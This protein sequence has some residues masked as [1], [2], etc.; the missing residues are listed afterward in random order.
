MKQLSKRILSLVLITSMVL[1][2]AACS[3]DSKTTASKEEPKTITLWHTWPTGTNKVIIDKFIEEYQQKNNVIIKAEATQVDEYQQR[4]LKVAISG[5]SVA[6]V[7]LTYGAGYSKPF[8]DAKAVL[9]LEPYLKKDE[10]KDRIVEGMAEYFTYNSKTYGLPIKSWAGVLFCNTELFKA[11]G[12]EIPK[13]MD[14]LMLAVKA[15]R[16]KDITPMV[17][18]AKDAWHIGMIQNALAVRTAGAEYV[19]KALKGEATFDTPEIVESAKLLVDL[20]KSDAFVKGTLGV[21]SDEAQME[22]FMSNVPMYYGGSWLPVDFESK[23]N[24]VQGKVKAVPMPIVEGGKGDATQFLGGSIEGY[25]VSSKTK[26]PEEAVKFAIAL[27]EYQSIEGYK[28]GDGVA[29]WKNN[30]DETKLNPVLAQVNEL[31]KG[32]TGY[33]LAWDTFLQGAAIDTHYNL[34]QGLIGGTVTPEQFAKKMQEASVESR[35][36]ITTK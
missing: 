14:E 36:S 27:S 5:N 12:V 34:L 28:L 32:S 20:F 26:Y 2:L 21:S 35:K 6:D 10:T 18:G 13:T 24:A 29:C 23:E 15:F 4:K 16:A 31:T 11:N 19:N 1:T 8:I 3:K 22:F 30:V 7:F 9:D 17:L 25:M 33:V